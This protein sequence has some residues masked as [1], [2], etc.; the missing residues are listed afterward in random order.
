MIIWHNDQLHSIVFS[1][2]KQIIFSF[3]LDL[4]ALPAT[5][6][7]APWQW[8]VTAGRPPLS[9]SRGA[10][11]LRARGPRARAPQTVCCLQPAH[12]GLLYRTKTMPQSPP[13]GR[14][15]VTGPLA[16]AVAGPVGP[17]AVAEE[18]V[19]AAGAGPVAAA[20]EAVAAGGG[21]GGGGGGVGLVPPPAPTPPVPIEARP[22]HQR[23]CL[24]ALWR[25][26]RSPRRIPLVII[27][28]RQRRRC[29]ARGPSN[30]RRRP[31]RQI[32]R[33]RLF[34]TDQFATRTDR[35]RRGDGRLLHRPRRQ[36]TGARPC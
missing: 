21:G 23:R 17:V 11:E 33:R 15:R 16:G 6:Y 1:G 24:S 5:C 28:A 2:T 31:F 8:P 18:A 30:L 32:E 20:E 22:T 19:A 3:R 25:P 34:K 35:V 29:R 9:R 7:L 4:V 10:A 14:R 36:R 27:G 12:G 13:Q 26:T